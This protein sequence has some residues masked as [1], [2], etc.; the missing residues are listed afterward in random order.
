MSK[1]SDQLTKKFNIISWAGRP[2]FVDPCASQKVNP[3]KMLIVNNEDDLPS[4]LV[5]DEPIL[6]CRWDSFCF[7]NRVNWKT[8]ELISDNYYL[9]FGVFCWNPEKISGN[10]ESRLLKAKWNGILEDYVVMLA[11]LCSAIYLAISVSGS[12]FSIS[13]LVRNFKQ[14]LYIFGRV[15]DKGEFYIFCSWISI[16]FWNAFFL[17]SFLFS[18]SAS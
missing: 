2:I 15:G 7:H 18:I 11:V 14:Q 6:I 13:F 16:A 12:W 8:E 3:L 10:P 17:L 1:L 9:E 4:P 5:C